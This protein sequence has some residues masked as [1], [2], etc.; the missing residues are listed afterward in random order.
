MPPRP[1]TT[2]KRQRN[3]A[4]DTKAAKAT[5]GTK[6]ILKKKADSFLHEYMPTST[7]THGL[8]NQ[9]YNNL[10]WL[11]KSLLLSFLPPSLP[12]YLP[13]CLEEHDLGQKRT[14]PCKTAAAVSRSLT[15]SFPPALPP[16]LPPYLPAWRSTTRARSGRGPVR[17]PRLC[18]DPFLTSSLPPSLPPS[19]PAWRSTTKARSEGGPA[20][21]PRRCRDPSRCTGW[22][23]RRAA[24]GRVPHTVFVE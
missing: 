1:L 16:S 23:S 8:P 2:T 15:S 9:M 19:L 21:Q 3:I 24:G 4:W 20:G 13:I 11:I 22:C 7:S 6:L 14:R 12:P 10:F 5:P 17:Q 18:R